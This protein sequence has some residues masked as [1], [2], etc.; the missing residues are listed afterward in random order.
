MAIQKYKPTSPGRRFM[1]SADFDEITT[2]VPYK[3]LV[4]SVHKK[5][6]EI[7]M[8]V[9]LLKVGVAVQKNYTGLSISKEINLIYK[10]PLKQ[11]NM[12]QTGHHE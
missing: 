2:N 8:D 11:L 7:I 4:K 10:V 9:L 6:V 5:R 3:P 12:I 1:T